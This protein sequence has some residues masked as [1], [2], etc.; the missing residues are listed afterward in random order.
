MRR[1]CLLDMG[2]GTLTTDPTNVHFSVTDFKRRWGGRH[3]E[4]LSVDITLARAKVL[5]QV[6]AQAAVGQDAPA[7][8]PG[9]SSA[10]QRRAP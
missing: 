4:V 3:V 2:A 10:S 8:P 9:L 5:F 6:P 1:L 7:L